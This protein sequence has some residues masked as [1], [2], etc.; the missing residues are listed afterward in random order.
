MAEYTTFRFSL[1]DG[2]ARIVLS[3]PDRGNP[4]DAV[5][6]REL[7]EI[8]Q[9]ISQN[10]AVRALLI[11]AEG[12]VFSAG[13]DIRVFAEAREALPLVVKQWTGELHVALA[14]M[15]RMRV[16][17]VAE[18][19]GN[20]GGGGLGLVAASDFIVAGDTVKFASGFA[21]LG[22]SSDSSTTT[23]LTQRMGWQ[24]AKRFL[25][26]AE[27]LEAP[28]AAAAGLVDFV[29]PTA[30]V[31]VEAEKLALRLAHGPTEAYGG[32][33]RLMIATRTNAPET[34]M[35]A[36]AQTLAAVVRTDDAWEGI[37]AFA[38]KRKP[39]FKGS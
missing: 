12:K 17:V 5:F 4:I 39:A 8:A 25:M 9:E 27:V 7:K 21:A 30:A 15:M 26:L 36:E 18:V 20:V 16:P 6:A 2:L 37:S 32:L 14:T 28:A 22:F 11:R 24:R 34:Q 23:S 1:T 10:A 38:A 33:K 3:R 35:E 13:G 29:V 31:A 19:A